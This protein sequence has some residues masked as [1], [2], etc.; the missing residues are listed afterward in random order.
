M[1]T[2][3]RNFGDKS[4]NE[5]RNIRFL[6]VWFTLRYMQCMSFPRERIFC[7]QLAT[8]A[9]VYSAAQSK[10]DSAYW[11]FSWIHMQRTYL[12][13]FFLSF[14]LLL[15]IVN[16]SLPILQSK[17]IDTNRREG[18]MWPIKWDQQKVELKKERVRENDQKIHTYKHIKTANKNMASV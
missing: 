12:L 15:F 9:Y 10:M 11:I 18:T 7:M 16:T 5:E 13:F 14:F 3:C 2:F 6:I 4:E 8:L 1:E 17:K